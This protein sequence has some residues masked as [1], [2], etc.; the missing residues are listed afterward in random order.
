MATRVILDDHLVE[1][2]RKVGH[3][4]T[5]TEAVTAALREYVTRAGQ[6]RILDLVGKVE[7]FPDYDHR[8]LRRRKHGR[9]TL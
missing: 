9:E 5:K 2:A 8:A 4:R 6:K 7:Y 1:L 3:H